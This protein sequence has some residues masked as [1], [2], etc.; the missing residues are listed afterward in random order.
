MKKHVVFLHYFGGNAESWQ[1]MHPYLATDIT[2]HYLSLPGFGSTPELANISIDTMSNYVWEYIKEQDL[3]DCMLV[4][5][6]MGGKLALRTATLDTE[7]RIAQILLVA[8]SPPTIE[9]MSESEQ[10]RMLDRDRKSCEE[11]VENGTYSTLSDN[12]MDFCI[13][14]QLMITENTWKWWIETGMKNSIK[15]YTDTLEIPI[16][17]IY[18]EDDQAIT[19]KMIQE[20]VIPNLNLQHVFHT[21]HVGHLMPIE[22][23]EYVAK[24]VNDIV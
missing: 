10:K 23:P 6:S 19:P 5:H 1:W 21:K 15:K 16:H 12:K 13:E 18:S 4:G 9:A 17:L 24:V 20:E 7:H 11:T 2:P 14:T 3:N 8:P 22:Q